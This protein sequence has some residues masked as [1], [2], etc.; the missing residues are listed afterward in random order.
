MTTE[1][2]EAAEREDTELDAALIAEFEGGGSRPWIAW[3]L[4]A[5]ALTAVGLWFARPGGDAPEQR[6]KTTPAERGSLEVLVT[7]TGRLEPRRT[8][9]VGAE[10]SGRI[11]EVLVDDNDLVTRDQVLVRIDTE[12]L[13]SQ[14]EQREASLDAATA[15]AQQSV[16]SLNEAELAFKRA[17][18]LTERGIASK[19]SLELQEAKRDRARAALKSSRAQERLA[20]AE[21]VVARANLE[22]AVIRSPNDG[23]V[24]SRLVEPG[25]TVAASLQTPTLFEI[26]ED[27]S[28]MSLEADV[29]EADIGPIHS[30][31]TATFTVDAWPGRSFPAE[32]TQ[33]RLAPTDTSGVITYKTLL[34]LDNNEGLLRPGMTAT[35]AIRVSFLEGVLLAPN[36][37]LRFQ[38][39][40]SSGGL[41]FGPPT[42]QKQKQTS[43][44]AVWVLRDG[45]PTRVVVEV[46][47]TDG[48]RSELRGEVTAGDL[49][50]IGEEKSS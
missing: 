27:L 37:A 46:G 19:E 31:L 2:I 29:D 7:A 20:R 28:V 3:V 30:G 33:V 1:S 40:Q 50:I 22:K 8:I 47:A 39:K 23:V 25:N 5:A 9:T 17:A 10:I 44:D 4:G 18:Q 14:L 42:A 43:D 11:V 35:V 45:Q 49:L 12:T 48:D 16:V 15:A 34:R 38:P 36:K 24:L 41:R 32:V 13:A 21:V 26:A 6:W